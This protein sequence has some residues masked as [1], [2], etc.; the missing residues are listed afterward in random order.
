M[1][2]NTE[3]IVETKDVEIAPEESL[4]MNKLSNE[5]IAETVNV[6]V[7]SMELLEPSENHE[8]IEVVKHTLLDILKTA[9]LNEENL[10]KISIKLNSEMINDIN[11]IISLTPDT[12]NDIELAVAEIIKDGKIDSNDVPQLIL[13]VQR[14]YQVIYGLKLDAKKRTELTS[15]VLKFVIHVLVLEGK[16]KIEKEKQDQFLKDCDLLIDSCIS[17]LSFPK[18]IKV[19]GCLKKLFA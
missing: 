11:K 5:L 4:E 13:L 14:I 7:G 8:V 10:N 3:Q 16:I 18:S 19:K 1:S 9:L 2:D 6:D 15:N 12:F 17:L